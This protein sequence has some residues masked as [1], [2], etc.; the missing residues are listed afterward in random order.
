[1]QSARDL[2]VKPADIFDF[3]EGATGIKPAKVRIFPYV[4]ILHSDDD[5]SVWPPQNCPKFTSAINS[6]EPFS[7]IEKLNIELTG[8]SSKT[9]HAINADM[10]SSFGGPY[11]CAARALGGHPQDYVVLLRV[12]AESKVSGFWFGDAGYIYFVIGKEKLKVH[13]FSQVYCNIEHIF[14]EGN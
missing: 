10:A 5:E 4:S 11:A 7:Q 2:S 3:H 6:E 1:L 14:H 12:G 9:L 13:D 8:H